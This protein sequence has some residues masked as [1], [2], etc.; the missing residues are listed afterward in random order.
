MVTSADGLVE[1]WVLIGNL[2]F[3]EFGARRASTQTRRGYLLPGVARIGTAKI[4]CSHVYFGGRVR[5]PAL[6]FFAGNG[7]LSEI[8]IN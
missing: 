5:G 4:V 2:D 3:S 7:V 1:K 6:K 8:D